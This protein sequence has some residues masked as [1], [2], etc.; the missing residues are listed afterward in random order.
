MARLREADPERY[1]HILM[2]LRRY[3]T[4]LRR[5]GL[6]DRHLDWEISARDVRIF[7]VRET[8]VGIVL[9]P[10]CALGIDR[11]RRAVSGNGIHRQASGAPA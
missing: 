3:D 7:A 1:D 9:L 11:V 4:R 5:F 8:I 2:R 6:R 10:L